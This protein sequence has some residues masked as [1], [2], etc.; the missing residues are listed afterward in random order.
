MLGQT[1]DAP[2]GDD[3]LGVA[4]P[5]RP[6]PPP[7]PPTGAAA[8]GVPVWVASMSTLSGNASVRSMYDRVPSRFWMAAN[9]GTLVVNSRVTSMTGAL[10][11]P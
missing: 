4:A 8:A 3:A 1:D 11:G 7:R 5:P 9:S 2:V 10:S 6:P